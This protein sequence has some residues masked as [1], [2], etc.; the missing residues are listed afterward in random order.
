MVENRSALKWILYDVIGSGSMDNSGREVVRSRK[1]GNL[2]D[3]EEPRS[4]VSQSIVTPEPSK[5]EFCKIKRALMAK[6]RLGSS[7]DNSSSQVRL[8]SIACSKYSGFPDVSNRVWEKSRAYDR[9]LPHS[10]LGVSPGPRKLI[11][12]SR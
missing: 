8:K 7:R 6:S 2:P 4:L 10:G 11:S 5:R 12:S 3:S 9:A 1:D